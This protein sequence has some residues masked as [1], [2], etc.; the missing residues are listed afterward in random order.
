MKKIILSLILVITCFLASAQ[1]KQQVLAKVWDAVGGKSN[2]EQTRFFEFVFQ[3]KRNDNIAVSRKHLWDRYT[4]N[5]RFEQEPEK[6]KVITVLFNVNTKM[7]QAYENGMA[8][9]DSLNAIT[10]KKAYASF[11][12]DTYW[13]MVPLKLEDPGVNTALEAD[14]VLNETKYK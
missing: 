3:V 8:L 13:L 2:Y 12:N 11:I 7:G 6:G 14:E 4:G 10:V 1:D 5:Y 9:T